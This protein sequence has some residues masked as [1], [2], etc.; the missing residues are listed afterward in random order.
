MLRTASVHARGLSRGLR[1]IAIDGAGTVLCVRALAPGRFARVRGAMW[2]L[3]QSLGD[4]QPRIGTTLSIYP[5]DRDW[6]TPALCDPHWQ[7]E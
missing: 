2:L 5:H 6:N 4:A 1:V 7:P 3:E